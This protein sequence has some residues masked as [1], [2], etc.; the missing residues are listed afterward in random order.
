M[1]V[2]NHFTHPEKR[3]T[4]VRE[5]PV[6]II[7]NRQS[8]PP[9]QTRNTRGGLTRDTGGDRNSITH[10]GRLPMD[11]DAELSRG[12]RYHRMGKTDEAGRIYEKILLTH[13]RHPDALHLAGCLAHQT[14]RPDV[15]AD[16]IK[17]AVRILPHHPFFHNSLGLVFQAGG[18]LDMA[19]AAYTKALELKPDLAEAHNNLGLAF[20]EQGLP[21]Q[22]ASCYRK[23]TA[24]SPNAPEPYNNLGN[25]LTNE[26]KADKALP[27]FLKAVK[28]RPDY[29]EAWN[30]M[31]VACQNLNRV[32]HAITC[33]GKALDLNPGFVDARNNLGIAYQHLG[34]T[35]HALDCFRKAL[36]LE[37]ENPDAH[38]HL[39]LL[40]LLQ[41]KMTEGWK[42]YEWRQLRDE[43]KNVHPWS[44]TAPGW[45]GTSFHGQTLLIR[46]EQGLGDT[47]QFVRYL[48]LVKDLGGKIIFEIPESLLNLFRNIPGAENLIPLTPPESSLP[49]HDL[50]VALMSIPGLLGTT[51][52]TVPDLVPYIFPDPRK[53][54]SWKRRMKHKGM[55]VGLVWAGNPGNHDD[56][57]RSCDLRHFLPLAGIPGVQFYGL[58]KGTAA[59]QANE[60]PHGMMME[61]LG[62]HLRDFSDTCAVIENLDLVISVDTA[63][64][65]LAGAMGKPVWVL[66]PYAPDW[67]WLLEREDSPWYPTMR[68]FRQLEPGNWGELFRRVTHQLQS[69][70]AGIHRGGTSERRK[71][72]Q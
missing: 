50:S 19:I 36:A 32:G 59:A 1:S 60:L 26:G 7:R 49:H 9:I 20:Q 54:T 39:S 63:V 5:S 24:F 70:S 47:I 6:R 40:L 55:G 2:N 34:E 35:N 72:M 69:V 30:N 46:S 10:C 18:R 43:W 13:P 29:P 62:K 51:L 14:G 65:H 57:N 45:D 38:F 23:A 41:G 15:A 56:R 37:P 48:P 3:T 71:T 25:L 16:L 53:T 12:L 44:D 27:L 17:R 33:Y 21:D 52:E 67:R 8:E 68:L 11:T 64:V 4:G 42:E 28:L 22:A 66:L 31:G 61:N 58:Q